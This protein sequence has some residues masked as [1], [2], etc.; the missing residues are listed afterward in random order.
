[1]KY[2]N[3]RYLLNVASGYCCCDLL[4][5]GSASNCLLPDMLASS[6]THSLSAVTDACSKRFLCG[7][8]VS[9][10][11]SILLRVDECSPFAL[12]AVTLVKMKAIRD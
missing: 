8:H 2:N 9:K 10:A 12:T 4:F 11:A 5:Y 6:A 7:F 1:M 3:V